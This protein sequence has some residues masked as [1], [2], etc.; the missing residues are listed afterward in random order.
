M[1]RAGAC[2]PIIAVGSVPGVIGIYR[3]GRSCGPRLPRDGMLPIGSGTGPPGAGAG[4][5]S[6]ASPAEEPTGI[7][8]LNP[9]VSR[10]SRLFLGSR[11]MI[12]L[13]YERAVCVSDPLFFLIRSAPTCAFRDGPFC[14]RAL[15]VQACSFSF[16]RRACQALVSQRN[17][18]VLHREGRVSYVLPEFTFAQSR[19]FLVPCHRGNLPSRTRCAI[20]GHREHDKILVTE[21]RRT[22]LEG[23]R[24]DGAALSCSDCHVART[25]SAQRSVNGRW[26]SRCA[27]ALNAS[28]PSGGE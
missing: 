9:G 7:G 20:D 5:A 14:G 18:R 23:D 27:F 10:M 17:L 13:L 6:K 11:A 26:L 12:H 24:F 3:V 19:R 28:F 15:L 16:L 8:V 25:D 2:C 1:P 21:R 4:G 22:A